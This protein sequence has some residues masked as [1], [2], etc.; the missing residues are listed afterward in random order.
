[1]KFCGVSGV[2]GEDNSDLARKKSEEI[3]YQVQ[4]R[5]FI[6]EL[7]DYHALVVVQ[8]WPSWTFALEGLG[9][10]SLST[11]ASFSSLGSRQEFL[12]T[13][14]G[15]TLINK[16]VL[17]EW[18]SAHRIDG[19]IFV[20]GDRKFLE[21]SHSQMGMTDETRLVYACSDE[22]FWSADGTRISHAACGGVTDGVWIVYTQNLRSSSFQLLAVRRTLRHVLSSVEGPSS[23]TSLKAANHVPF[24]VDERV[25]WGLKHPCVTTPSVYNKGEDANRFMTATELMDA[26]DLELHAQLCLKSL[27]MREHTQPSYGFVEQIPSKVL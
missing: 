3:G 10:K 2:L 24:D 21:M 6:L 22:T 19:V 1:M 15:A 5:T 9:W 4:S 26:Y 17:S 20:Q 18:L 14:S 25:R 8:G 12:A 7:D 11:V 27:W 23:A 13:K 16:R